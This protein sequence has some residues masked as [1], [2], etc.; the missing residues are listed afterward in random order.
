MSD[1][2]REQLADIQHAIWAHWMGYMFGCGE[3]RKDD[4][5]VMPAEK[6][7]RWWR[8]KEAPYSEL[9]DKE[10]ESDRHQADKILAVVQPALAAANAR[11]EA[12]ERE[13]AA[14]PMEAIR[15]Y[16][17]HSDAYAAVQADTYEMHEGMNDCQQIAEWLGRRGEMQP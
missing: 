13:L 15:R 4:T 1:E 10:R 5:W 7:E 2:L 14:V 17:D 12:A 16:F 11:A 6:L 8:Q 3:F 9:S